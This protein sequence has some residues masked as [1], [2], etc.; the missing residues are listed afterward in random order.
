[1]PLRRS[2][3]PP[4]CDRVHPAPRGRLRRVR[5]GSPARRHSLVP[6]VRQPRSPA[7]AVVRR[8]LCQPRRLPVARGPRGRA[9]HAAADLHWHVAGRR[10]DLVSAVGSSRR[11]RRRCSS[12]IR[13]SVRAMPTLRWCTCGPGRRSS[14]RN[15]AAPC[16]P[17]VRR[18]PII[19]QP[20]SYWSL[21][22]IMGEITEAR[23]AGSSAAIAATSARL[24]A[25]TTT[26]RASAGF[27]P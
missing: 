21:S 24:V 17:P 22:A 27:T 10:R 3:V 23:R 6:G 18:V 16:D 26:V 20:W 4:R 2:G 9:T 13:A 15:F 7:R 14:C 25:A 19:E 8:A 11:R 1:M 5:P 12:S